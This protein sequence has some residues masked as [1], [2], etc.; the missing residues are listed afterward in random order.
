MAD[1]LHLLE[2]TKDGDMAARDELVLAN[3]GLVK[4]IARRYTGRGQDMDDLIQIGLIGLIKAIDRFD[5]SYEVQ[6]STYAVPLITGELRRFLR[7]DGIIKVSRS[8]KSI[9]YRV[10]KYRN[11]VAAACGREPTTAEICDALG[12]SAE[13]VIM[14][15]EA[16]ADVSCIDE[17]RE[18]TT[19]SDGG[20]EVIRHLYVS[21]LL[22]RLSANERRLIYMRY[23]ENKTQGQIGE[24]L[25]MSQV[26]VSRLEKRI[27]KKM[28]DS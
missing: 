18:E 21:Q 28:R 12:E 23:F 13:D 26:Q 7:D 27:L 1:N 16:G 14:A 8:V 22:N 4:S 2:R 6:F 5:M 11:E 15:M 9:Y 24:L 17:V 19:G 20:D 25:G 3:M 10:E